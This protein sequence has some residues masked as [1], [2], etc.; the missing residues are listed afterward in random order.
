MKDGKV[1]LRNI[2]LL[3]MGAAGSGKSATKDLLLGNPPSE[4]RDSTICIRPVTNLQIK[5]SDN[6]WKEVSKQDLINM[7]AQAIHQDSIHQDSQSREK[8]SSDLK[9]RL[10]KFPTEDSSN[11]NANPNSPSLEIEQ[12]IE[13]VVTLVVEALESIPSQQQASTESKKLSDTTIRVTDTGGQPQFH[14]VAPLFIQHASAGLF[15]FRLTDDFADYPKDDLYTDGNLVAPPS[16]SHLSYLETNMS[17]L[18]SFLSKKEGHTPLPIFVGTFLDRIE[19]KDQTKVIDKKNQALIDV[20]PLE[21]KK[22][23]I[24]SNLSLNQVIFPVNARS[25]DENAQKASEDIRNAMENSPTFDR[26]VPLWWFI[27]ELALQR[28]C[29]IL[30]RGILHKSEC[31][32]LAQQLG[33]GFNLSHLNAAL[34]YFDEICIV[35]YYPR[36]LPDLVFLDPQIPLDKVSELTQHA[37]APRR[38]WFLWLR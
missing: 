35:H 13:D 29:A 7:L 20:L 10:K 21:V 26:D 32:A 22:K 31:I 34:N 2:N 28:L 14:D 11:A 30:K 1:S 18:R 37:I 25:R 9:T 19:G 12:A 5:S 36:I 15:V 3:L 4:V 33:G 23:V 16:P 24:F 38:Q 8:L 27:L 6:K 17:L